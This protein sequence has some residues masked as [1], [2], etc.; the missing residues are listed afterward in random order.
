MLKFCSCSCRPKSRHAGVTVHPKTNKSGRSR[1]YASISLEDHNMFSS[2]KKVWTCRKGPAY[3]YK[4]VTH[5]CTNERF[6][7]DKLRHTH[8]HTP[9]LS[10]V[11][12]ISLESCSRKLLTSAPWGLH[13]QLSLSFGCHQCV[14]VQQTCGTLRVSWHRIK[15]VPLITGSKGFLTVS[16]TSWMPAGGENTEN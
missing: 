1:H 5:E 13:V 9:V 6:Q 15:L 3:L 4:T 2:R 11:W 7:S 8:T 10:P 16:R 14:A 12:F